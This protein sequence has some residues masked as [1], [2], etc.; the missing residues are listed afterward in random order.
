MDQM[1]GLEYIQKDFS[2]VVETMTES[3]E[4]VETLIVNLEKMKRGHVEMLGKLQAKS[5]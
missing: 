3:K 4:R 5:D 1:K 2:L